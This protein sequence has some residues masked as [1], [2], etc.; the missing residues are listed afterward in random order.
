ME[1]RIEDVVDIRKN[2]K[3]LQVGGVK[4]R[5]DFVYVKNTK[6][7]DSEFIRHRRFDKVI[8]WGID[9]REVI[10]IFPVVAD[11]SVGS[12]VMFIGD[13]AVREKLIDLIETWWWP[14]TA[15]NVSTG[16]GDCILTNARG[17]GM[18]GNMAKSEFLVP[19]GK[20]GELRG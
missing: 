5:D 19:R 17:F 20:N 3:V 16:F 9:E 15:Y 18:F 2:E 12:I 13:T 7:L 11:L 8:V 4:L 10:E 14:A 1:D 6:E